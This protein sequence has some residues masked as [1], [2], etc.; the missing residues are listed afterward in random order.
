M[1][2][3][4]SRSYDLLW[5]SLA[6]LP[7]V[8][9]SFLFSIHAMDYW[10]YLRI[11]HETLLNGFVPTTDT[12]S[13]TQAGK[14]VIYQPWLAGVIFWWIYD[15]GG[16]TLTYLLR[17]ILLVGTFGLLWILARRAAGPRLATVLILIM[18]L[19]SSNN[20]QMRPQLFAYPLF[21][22]CLY[23]LYNWQDGNDRTLWALPVS[24]LLWS[25]LHGSFVLALVLAGTALVFGKGNRRSLLI[26]I[27]GI[28]LAT[29]V[30]PR[31]I[32]NWRF[33]NFMLHSPSD[34]IFS[35]EW[36][37]PRNEGW[38]LNIF[39]AWTLLLA[40]L[41]ALSP[42]KP[43]L[44]EWAFFL[45]FGWL[46]FS[47]IRYVIWF[48]FLL[49]MITAAPLAGL[50]YGKLDMPAKTKSPI[51]NIGIIIIFALLTLLYLPGIR[52]R[53]WS[54]APAVY[55]PD[56]NPIYAVAWLKGHPELPGPMW[57][58]FAFGSYLAFA[59]PGRPTWLDTRF[60]VFPPEQMNEYQKIS[61]G[62]REW[63][64]LL[65]RSRINLLF[66]SVSG[67]SQLVENVASSADWCEQYRD[68][69]AVIF[70]R[71]NPIP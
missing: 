63:D 34:Q 1:N 20:W 3:N 43:S 8:A 53:W 38:Q 16:A 69:Y 70:S 25:N 33:L 64:T 48:L 54:E 47:G 21:V 9:L 7:L 35:L 44:T 45:S 32:D 37:P 60:F 13:W 23:S 27:G 18:A 56:S 5:L 67:Q 50:T 22:V 2:P 46:A 57:N 58:D 59:L 10:W 39:F 68:K 26:T 65:Q 62:S 11:G 15:L 52:E 29:F 6:V 36:L 31:G 40:P 28:V 55:S 4:P 24:V 49:P 17:A 66:L 41:A 19:A 71:C 51:F 42:R 30:C 12:I 61:H 14:P